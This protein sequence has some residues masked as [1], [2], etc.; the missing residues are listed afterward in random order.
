[1]N[2]LHSENLQY[3]PATPDY[4]SQ[5]VNLLGNIST[6]TLNFIYGAEE[7]RS[8]Y[9]IKEFRGE[10]GYFS[11]SQH[12]LML[13]DDRCIGVIAAYDRSEI[14][15]LNW[16]TLNAVFAFYPL[17]QA[18]KCLYKLLVS[19]SATPKPKGDSCFL[20][21]LS[22]DPEF[23]RQGI[24]SQL[25]E[26]EILRAR[27]RKYKMIELDV[28]TTN[29]RAISLYRHHGFLV[30]QQINNPRILNGFR[31]DSHLRMSLELQ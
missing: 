22:V 26:Q 29:Q 17:P 20:Y 7:L 4:A 13:T 27:N 11:Y 16:G 12:R 19:T 23:S 31:F 3:C 24:G 28:A 9:L 30:K 1:M 14:N 21:N 2:K 5:V 6:D 8:R 15:R 25:L 18:I 10:K